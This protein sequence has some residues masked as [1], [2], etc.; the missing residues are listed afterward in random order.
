MDVRVGG[1]AT[2]I[3]LAIASCGLLYGLALSENAEFNRAGLSGSR[4]RID[5]GHRFGVSVGQHY[6]SAAARMS[7]LGFEERELTRRNSCHGFD[8]S[9]D[10]KP[11]LWLDNSWR[12]GTI[13]LVVSDGSIKFISWWYG[14]G[15]P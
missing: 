2:A 10:L 4:G 11:V 7:R 5:S 6:E 3:L 1:V 9:D 13:C 14:I 8:Y 15:N 12:K